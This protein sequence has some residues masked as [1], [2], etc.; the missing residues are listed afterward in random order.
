MDMPGLVCFIWGIAFCI[1]C[2]LFRFTTWSE[3]DVTQPVTDE[4]WRNT[5]KGLALVPPMIALVWPTSTEKFA[6]DPIPNFFWERLMLLALG[7]F[8]GAIIAYT[9]KQRN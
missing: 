9:V 6:F 2:I 5:P 8:V 3:W 4:T 7:L 1:A